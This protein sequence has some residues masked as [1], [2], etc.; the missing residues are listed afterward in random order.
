MKEYTKNKEIVDLAKG[1]EE[2]LERVQQFLL[3]KG[4]WYKKMERVI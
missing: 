3:K 4:G 2:R 1:S